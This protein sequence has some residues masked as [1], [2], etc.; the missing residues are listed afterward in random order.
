[1]AIEFDPR[2]AK[3]AADAYSL[4]KVRVTGNEGEKLSYT[5]EDGRAF[6]LTINRATDINYALYSRQ[7]GGG[8]VEAGAESSAEAPKGL[9]SDPMLLQA[10]K[11]YR[12]TIISQLLGNFGA[13]GTAGLAVSDGAQPGADFIQSLQISQDMKISMDTVDTEYW[14]VENTAGRLVDFAKALIGGG[15]RQGNL[16][17]VLD[18]IDQGF[19]AAKEAFGGTLPDISQKTVDLAKKMLADWAAETVAQPGQVNVQA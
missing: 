5:A 16:Q 18:G 10:I 13:E 11:Q 2:A 12:D 7:S 4:K 8:R 9:G 17:K 15:D 1:M 3:P 14:S 6:N 19:A